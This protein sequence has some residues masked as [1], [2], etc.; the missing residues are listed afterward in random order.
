MLWTVLLVILCVGV[1]AYAILAQAQFGKNPEGADVARMQASKHYVAGAFANTVPTPMLREGENVLKLWW[2]TLTSDKKTLRPPKPLPTVK[3]DLKALNPAQDVLIWLGHSSY[4]VQLAG[5]RFLVDPVFSSYGAPFSFVN[6][7]FA[8]TDI[9]TA[10]DMPALDFLLL[11]HDHWDHLD[12][13]TA[14]ALKDKVTT[15]VSPLGVTGHLARW[16]YAPE[17]LVEAD[18][19]TALDFAGGSAQGGITVHVVTARHF[20]GRSFTRNKTQWGGF[21]L[22]SPQRRLFFSGDSGFG[23]HFEDIASRFSGFD[24]ALLDSGQYDPRWPFVHMTPEEA[25]QAAQVLGA[26]AMLLGHTGRFA[27]AAHDW[28]EPYK[29]AEAA[30]RALQA[31]TLPQWITPRLGEPVA[32]D[33]T[34]WAFSRWW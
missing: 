3:L 14:L 2:K 32:L 22:E 31:G 25:V 26:K 18:W 17:R 34:G 12:H 29:R 7:T 20:S 16:G 27:I 24:L 4:Y 23:P 28:D 10:A 19:D 11:S 15:V 1:A 6:T 5:K 33:G 13:A 8:G 30:L 21:V 9:Y